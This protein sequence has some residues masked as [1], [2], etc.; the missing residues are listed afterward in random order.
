M[1]QNMRISYP[2]HT[3]T[4]LLKVQR[5]YLELALKWTVYLSLELCRIA[6]GRLGLDMS[7]DKGAE[8]MSR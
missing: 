3:A 6:A 7:K 2:V 4:P 1:P 8:E 5:V